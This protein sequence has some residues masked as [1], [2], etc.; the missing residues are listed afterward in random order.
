[1]DNNLFG[2][3]DPYQLLLDMNDLLN[4][5]TANHN[6]LVKDYAETQKRLR[7]LEMQ[8]NELRRQRLL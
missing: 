1:V 4:R 3:N 6:E 5:L 8:V 2:D 7:R